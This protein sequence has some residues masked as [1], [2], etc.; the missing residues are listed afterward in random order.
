[1][2]S[3]LD[4]QAAPTQVPRR[5]PVD[6]PASL[7]VA[8][9][10]AQLARV[11][12]LTLRGAF[13]ATATPAA[14]GAVV[15]PVLALPLAAGGR[16]VGVTARVRWANEAAAPRSTVLPPG[17]GVQGVEVS[18]AARDAPLHFIAERLGTGEARARAPDR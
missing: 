17:L 5:L 14:P 2:T 10:P 6:V 9:A 3:R 7:A 11:V 18:Q 1:M 15:E 13:V 12:N 8:G 16:H 4:D